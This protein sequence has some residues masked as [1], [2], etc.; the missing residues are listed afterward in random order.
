MFDCP[1]L[2]ARDDVAMSDQTDRTFRGARFH[3]ADFTGATFRECEMNQVKILGCVIVDLHVSGFA[4]EI[5]NVVVNDVDVTAF[6]EAELDRRHPERVQLRAVQTADDYRTMWNTIERLWS[7]TIARAERLPESVSQ[8]RVNDEWSLVETLRHLIFATNVWI[9]RMILGQPMPYHRLSLPPSDYPPAD[10]AAIGLDLP[11]RPSMAEVMEVRADHM[12]LVRRILANATD[13]D[14]EQ[15]RTAEPAPG[16][17]EESLSVG[18]C[19][20]VVLN[21]ECEHH[22]YVVRDLGLLG[23]Q[24]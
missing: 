16:W 22:R 2:P 18:R 1:D 14:L 4:G 10:A 6:V 12:A 19:L 7:D 15:M 23:A 3:G 20:R 8:D 11:A 17:G 24:M 21:E 5:E 9:G 13:L